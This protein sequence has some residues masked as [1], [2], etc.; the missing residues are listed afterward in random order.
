MNR[1]LIILNEIQANPS[2]S[3]R[4]LTTLTGASLGT[5]NGELQEMQLQGW[6]EINKVP[7]VK[8]IYNLTDLGMEHK[9]DLMYLEA[10]ESFQ[11]ISKVRSKTK[12]HIEEALQSG[13][14]HF[15]VVG[16]EDEVYRLI[17][18]SLLDCKRTH[19]LSYELIS[20]DLPENFETQSTFIAWDQKSKIYLK[21][22]KK[23]YIDLFK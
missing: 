2:V 8:T 3:Q 18:M 21:S 1:K 14:M 23:C 7:N 12:Q 22:K 15:Y 10:I 17:K 4:Q 6:L 13:I 9:A 19:P 5:I 16:P 11:T 20:N